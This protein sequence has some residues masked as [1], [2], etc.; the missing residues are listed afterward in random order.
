MLQTRVGHKLIPRAVFGATAANANCVRELWIRL[1][2]D[3]ADAA[4]GCNA[5]CGRS[6]RGSS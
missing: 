1:P 3:F 4:N 6:N 5:G 2:P